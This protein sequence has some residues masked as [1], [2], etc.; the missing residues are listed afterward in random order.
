MVRLTSQTGEGEPLFPALVK[1][2]CFWG[3]RTVSTL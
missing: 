3:V 1:R 2:Q